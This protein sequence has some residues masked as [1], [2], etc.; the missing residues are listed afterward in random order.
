MKTKLRGKITIIFVVI[1]FVIL[2]VAAFCVFFDEAVIV[3]KDTLYRA[4]TQDKV[5][6]LTFDDGPSEEWTPKILDVL[7]KYRVKATFF[8]IGE[9]VLQ[10]PEIAKR[11]AQEGHEIG[12]HT[13]DHHVLVYYKPQE[14]VDE[15]K[16]AERVIQEAT[17]RKTELLRPPKAWVTPSEKIIIN[18]LG[19]KIILW[20]LNSKDW[21]NFDDK[22]IVR[23]LMHNIKPGDIILFH[24]SGG[25]FTAEGGNR[26][27]TIKAVGRLIEKLRDKGYRLATVSELLS[28]ERK[29]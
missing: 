10:Y 11:V 1:I 7:N 18:K 15:I 2:L 16:K 9:H 12:N 21:V 14:L 20:S 3:R 24:D 23:Y 6:A 8:M 13:F 4:Q 5:V 19:Y 26:S 28:L 25:V 22:Y 29:K 27:E 17:G